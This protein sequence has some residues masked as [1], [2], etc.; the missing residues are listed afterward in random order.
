MSFKRINPITDLL[1][2]GY[3]HKLAKDSHLVLIIPEAI[4]KIIALFYP[5]LLKYT[6]ECSLKMQNLS[7]ALIF[8]LSVPTKIIKF[9]SMLLSIIKQQRILFVKYGTIF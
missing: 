7:L 8:A 4:Y 5:Q 9:L 1:V 2:H 6:L 3:V